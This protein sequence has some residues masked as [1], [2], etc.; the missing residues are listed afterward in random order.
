MAKAER[1]K[2]MKKVMNQSTMTKLL[3]L[4][5]VLLTAVALVLFLLSAAKNRQIDKEND[6]RY[7]LVENA[8]RFMNASS[9]LTSE[10]RQFAATGDEEHY[11]NYIEEVNEIKDRDIGVEN[12][13]KI[14]LTGSE[15]EM[16]EKMAGLSNELVP[17]EE[18]AMEKVRDGSIEEAMEYVFGDEYADTVAQIKGLQTAFLESLTGRSTK[19]VEDLKL[20]SQVLQNIA[21]VFMGIMAVI[22]LISLAVI[23]KK[24]L[25]PLAV[26]R[27]EMEEIAAGNLSGTSKME[28]DTSEIG[29]L[30]N[31][32][33]KTKD[34]MNAYIHDISEKLGQMAQGDMRVTVELDYIGDFKPIKTAIEKISSSLRET[35]LQIQESAE[36]VL[37][38]ANQVSAGAQSLAQ[39]STEQASTLEEL[40]ASFMAVSNQVKAN[41]NYSK[42]AEEMAEGAA[43]AIAGSDQ[44][45]SD[46]MDAMEEVNRHS[47]NISQIIKSIEDIA[48]QTNILALNAAVEAARAGE[49]GKGFAVVADEVRNLAGKSAVAASDTTQMIESTIQA[50]NNGMEISREAVEDLHKLVESAEKTTELVKSVSEGSQGQAAAIGEVELGVEQITSVVQ[51]NSATSEESAATSQELSSQAMMMRRLVERFKV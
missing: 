27:D 45:M 7:Y 25:K 12:M 40:S 5:S 50:V 18:K 21:I 39:G 28:P 35:L 20:Q 15:E 4:G 49:A 9:K 43:H 16:V 2:S 24:L 32:M 47:S 8:N 48:F 34:T 37:T 44:R 42:E 23:D 22:Q 38:G 41:A 30:V 46:L 11:N 31:S 33:R 19:T 6:N 10:V 29:M 14:G 51:T 3:N 1:M 17:L 13:R 36:Q 26:I